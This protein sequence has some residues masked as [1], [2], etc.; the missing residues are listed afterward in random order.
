MLLS[1]GQHWNITEHCVQAELITQHLVGPS[2]LFSQAVFKSWGSG[3]TPWLNSMGLSSLPY[4]FHYEMRFLVE[5]D[6]VRNMMVFCGSLNGRWSC[7]RKKCGKGR[8]ICNQNVNPVRIVSPTK[9]VG[10]QHIQLPIEWLTGPPLGI[11]PYW[12]SSVS[13]CC[14]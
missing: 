11:K 9:M 5:D 4:F 13:L 7:R 2:T 8:Q 6:V 1:V 12:G 14:I 3:K 10:N